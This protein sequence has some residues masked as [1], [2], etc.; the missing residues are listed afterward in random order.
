VIVIKCPT[1]VVTITLWSKQM[2]WYFYA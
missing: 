2:G 1:K